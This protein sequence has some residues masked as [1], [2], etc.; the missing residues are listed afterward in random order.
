MIAVLTGLLGCWFG[1]AKAI[2]DSRWI[3]FSHALG[4]AQ[5]L[6]HDGGLT[7]KGSENLNKLSDV[8]IYSYFSTSPKSLPEEQKEEIEGLLVNL[9]NWKIEAGFSVG[10]QQ[11]LGSLILKNGEVEIEL[12]NEHYLQFRKSFDSF[13]SRKELKIQPV[14]GG[15]RR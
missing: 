13:L 5:I 10:P 6:R 8:W 1:Y 15:Q 12:Q 9:I 2:R 7:K 14:D 3:E 4:L 11:P